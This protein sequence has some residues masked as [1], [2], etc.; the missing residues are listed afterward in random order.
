MENEIT[1]IFEQLNENGKWIA[2][3]W[4]KILQ[5]AHPQEREEPAPK[6]SLTD[7]ELRRILEEELEDC[8]Q[9]EGYILVGWRLGNTIEFE[10][11][12]KQKRHLA[13]GKCAYL[14]VSGDRWIY[15]WEFHG[16]Y[17]GATD[18]AR[19]FVHVVEKEERPKR[20][21]RKEILNWFNEPEPSQFSAKL[22]RKKCWIPSVP[23]WLLE[24]GPDMRPVYLAGGKPE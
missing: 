21:R 4:M 13:P 2:L 7:A 23:R 20:Y 10:K 9:L 6:R 22:P 14:P 16:Q 18:A 17:V 12:T 3:R 8:L 15:V 1:R 5:E 11:P 24:E 19:R